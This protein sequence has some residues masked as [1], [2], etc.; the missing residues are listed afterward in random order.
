[1]GNTWALTHLLFGD[2]RAQVHNNE[3]HGPSGKKRTSG[4]PAVSN[5]F[6]I[7]EA[8]RVPNVVSHCL[9]FCAGEMQVEGSRPK[10]QEAWVSD[11]V[12][13]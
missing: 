13:P 11:G 1:M 2:F 8:L 7:H 4:A 3:V 6:V 5:C 10:R 9:G 12:E